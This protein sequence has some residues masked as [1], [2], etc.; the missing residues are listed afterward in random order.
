MKPIMKY[1]TILS[2]LSERFPS[3]HSVEPVSEGE[4][5][6]ATAKVHPRGILDRARHGE[7][8][9][10]RLAPRATENLT[11]GDEAIKEA[12]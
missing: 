9:G 5:S 11:E 12:R 1:E 7:E 6:Q 3:I 4:E 2:T 10:R 8:E